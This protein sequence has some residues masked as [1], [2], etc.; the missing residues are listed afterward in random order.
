LPEPETPVT[1]T[2][3]PT[4]NSTSMSLRLCIDAPR[5]QKEPLSSVRR[6]GT[7]ISRAPDRNCP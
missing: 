6:S 1:Q 2:N 5:T 3:F 4:G 7:A